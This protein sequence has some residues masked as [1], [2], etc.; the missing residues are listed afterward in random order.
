VFKDKD[1]GIKSVANKRFF[2]FDLKRK[3]KK[4][5]TSQGFQS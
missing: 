1:P 4:E 5:N 3:K 2:M